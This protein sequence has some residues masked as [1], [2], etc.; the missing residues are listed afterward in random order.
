LQ[1]AHVQKIWDKGNHNAFTDII[2]KDGIFYCVFREGSGHVSPDGAIRILSSED[3]R[4]WKSAG[5][6][7]EKG[8]DL[9]D[10]KITISPDHQLQ[11]HGGAAKRDGSKPATDHRSFVYVSRDGKQWSDIQWIAEPHQWLWRVTW[12]QNTAY[13]VAYHVAPQSRSTRQFG[14]TL[15]TANDGIS[16]TPLVEALFQ[17]HGPTEATLRFDVDGKGY[18]LQRR[19]GKESNTALLG[20]SAP[21]Y[22]EWQW[23]DLGMYFGGPDFM[24]IETVGWIAAGRIFT[25]N[26]PTTQL[27]HLSVEEGTL[28][29]LLTLPSGGDTSYPGMVWEDNHLWISYYSSH[30]GKTCI[31]LAAI[32]IEK[33]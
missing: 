20:S 11:I 7:S 26:G 31:Y 6:L 14:T 15:L 27:C 29:P 5:V 21:P 24:F 10:P 17:E 30:E 2:R 9:R 32:T 1:I 8:Y 22:R 33:K 16:F 28:T 19:D 25:D 18:C 3:G 12:F 23:K 4:A 13:G